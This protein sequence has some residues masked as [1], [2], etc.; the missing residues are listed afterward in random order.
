MGDPAHAPSAAAAATAGPARAP[1][2]AAVEA[3]P[4][5]GVIGGGGGRG[6]S[7]EWP[8]LADL[9]SLPPGSDEVGAAIEG[10]TAALDAAGAP[11]A[12]K[13]RAFRFMLSLG[14]GARGGERGV[15]AR[16]RLLYAYRMLRPLCARRDAEGVTKVME[17]LVEEEAGA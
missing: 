11:A 5:T 12:L 16:R 6:G 17:L 13:G 3:A 14:G 2:Q 10:A 15:A 9:P 7:G 1:S 4:S 8:Q